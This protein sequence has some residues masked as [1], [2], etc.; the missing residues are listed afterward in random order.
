MTEGYLF[1]S[2]LAAS[3]VL[4][5]YQLTAHQ[6]LR[7]LIRTG[8]RKAERDN[9]QTVRLPYN[10]TAKYMGWKPEFD[11]DVRTSVYPFRDPKD[12]HAKPGRHPA[13]LSPARRKKL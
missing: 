10:Q 2:L 4:N 3:L 7:G 8:L 5:V 9:R 11:G 1:L 12:F 13:L 6:R